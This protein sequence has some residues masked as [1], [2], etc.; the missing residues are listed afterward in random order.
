MVAASDYSH[1]FTPA[2]YLEWEEK[3]ELRYEY[4]Y[5]EV[6]AMTG[7]TLN[8]SKIAVNF[9]ALVSNY[10]RGK[11]CQVFNSDAKVEVFNLDLF[12]Y[13]DLSVTCDD[14]DRS[15]T[16]FLSYPCLIVEVLSSSTEAYDRG[17]K[18]A[19][20]RRSASLKEYVLVSSEAIAVD[21]Y[22]PNDRGKW[23][24]TAYEPGDVIELESINLKF[25][26]EEL[27][28]DITFAS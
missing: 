24:L 7:G 12:L 14:R 9:I 11:R 1:R 3:Q 19:L 21:I 26:I 20:Y 13:P 2:E 23:E 6:Y 16:K 22:R 18:F 28:E 5:G 27:F 8:H 17:N 15:N 4:V 25:A 10:L